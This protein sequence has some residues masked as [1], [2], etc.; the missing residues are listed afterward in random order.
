MDEAQWGFWAS[1]WSADSLSGWSCGVDCCFVRRE[2]KWKWKT[3]SGTL[4]LQ[5]PSVV[6]NNGLRQL[7]PGCAA[8]ARLLIGS[9]FLLCIKP[10]VGDSRL[11]IIRRPGAMRGTVGHGRPDETN[12]KPRT[13]GRTLPDLWPRA[14]NPARSPRWL[15]RYSST[16]LDARSWFPDVRNHSALIAG[17]GHRRPPVGPRRPTR[18]TETRGSGSSAPTEQ[19]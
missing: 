3:K 6:W 7:L 10:D 9:S 2:K 8:T 1:D 14:W 15:L 12:Q 13:R 11:E 18:P 17:R 16:E 4:P 5:S 19:S